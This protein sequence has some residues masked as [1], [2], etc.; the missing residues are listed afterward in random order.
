MSTNEPTTT[1]SSGSTN[2]EGLPNPFAAG[3]FGEI[4]AE[5]LAQELE[6]YREPDG[7]LTLEDAQT[8]FEENLPAE[9]ANTSDVAATRT[10]EEAANVFREGYSETDFYGR[11]ELIQRFVGDV[12]VVVSWGEDTPDDDGGYIGVIRKDG[13]VA[14]LEPEIPEMVSPPY[15]REWFRESDTAALRN[16]GLSAVSDY[17]G[18]GPG[19]WVADADETDAELRD[20]TLCGFG[21]LHRYSEAWANSP[22][23]RDLDER[24][25]A[26]LSDFV[27]DSGLEEHAARR[28][29][30]AV[31]PTGSFETL[32]ERD[33]IWTTWKA[34][35]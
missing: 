29:L 26:V 28:R 8:F 21:F 20:L 1:E 27:R 17:G 32:P 18:L 33:A 7:T 2:V 13:W 22:Y 34:L 31:L 35:V 10:A 25:G 3:D 16:V 15:L 30:A 6:G 5:A 12:E 23:A 11:E 9:F 24:I 4:V 19:I 14:V